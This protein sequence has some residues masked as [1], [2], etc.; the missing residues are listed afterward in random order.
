RS[1][2]CL[3]ALNKFPECLQTLN[4]DVKE[5]PRNPDL[6]VL[7]AAFYERFG[8]PA[9][10]HPDIQRALVLEPQHGAAHALKQ[11]LLRRGREAKAEAVTK[12]LCGDLQGALLKV[13]FAI[14][15]DPSAADL[16]ILRGTLLRRLQNFT[17]AREDLTRVRALVAAGSPEAREAQRQLMLTHNDCA[18]RCYA[19]GLFEEAVGLLGEALQDEK[20]EEGLYI[21]RG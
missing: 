15:N 5:D 6:L 10:C 2:A 17:A 11:R 7:R 1:V 12:A 13:S 19:L 16:F 9:L 3:A 8:Q 21:N 14:E 4:R 18:A 20:H